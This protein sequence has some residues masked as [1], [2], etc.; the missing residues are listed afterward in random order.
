MRGVSDIPLA[1]LPSYAEQDTR[2]GGKAHYSQIVARVKEADPLDLPGLNAL[3]DTIGRMSP[4]IYEH[5]RSLQDLFRENIRRLLGS[6]CQPDGSY[7]T[8]TDEE[9]R[10]LK[11][12]LQK[13]C[14]DHTLLREK[15]QDLTIRCVPLEGAHPGRA[16]EDGR[17]PRTDERKIGGN[18]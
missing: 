8:A 7:Q 11:D 10:Q 9:L 1:E 16:P 14:A 17:H 15:Y 18:I 2:S 13:A 4:E 3:I 6:I 5:Y 12:C